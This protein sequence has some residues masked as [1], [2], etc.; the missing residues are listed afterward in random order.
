MKWVAA[1]AVVCLH[2]PLLTGGEGGRITFTNRERTFSQVLALMSS[3][4]GVEHVAGEDLL[5]QSWLDLRPVLSTIEADQEATIQALAHALGTWWCRDARG[6]IVFTQARILPALDR[7]SVVT[8]PSIIVDGLAWEPW[9]QQ[10]LE[11]WLGPDCAVAFHPAQQRWVATLDSAGQGR[12]LQILAAIERAEPHVPPV[13]PVQ[14]AAEPDRQLP[15]LTCASWPELVERLSDLGRISISLAPELARRGPQRL[16]IPAG[17]VARLPQVLAGLGVPAAWQAQVLCLGGSLRPAAHPGLQR[18][19]VVIPMAQFAARLDPQRCAACLTRTV[20]PDWWRQ[21]GAGLAW[22]P[23]RRALLAGVD[24]EA[25]QAI[26]DQLD[27]WDRQGLDPAVLAEPA[28][29]GLETSARHPGQ[30]PP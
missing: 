13:L 8:Y 19:L 28:G 23:D 11:P 14:G 10:M 15:T 22:H 18:H 1:L 17:P 4:S 29:R 30:L 5:G 7:P 6:Q 27:T 24:Q 21:P 3:L 16:V 12:L 2:G 26:L 20:C 9:V 25:L